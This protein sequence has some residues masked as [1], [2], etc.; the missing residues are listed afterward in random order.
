VY[1]NS[2]SGYRVRFGNS[3]NLHYVV[4]AFLEENAHPSELYAPVLSAPERVEN[5]LLPPLDPRIGVL[6]RRLATGLPPDGQARAIEAYLQKEFGYTTELLEQRVSDP[7]AHFLFNR[8]KGHCEY[9]SSAMA[10]MLRSLNIPARVANGFQ[11]GVFNPVSG[12]YVIRASDAHSWVEAW[13]PGR[14]WTTFDPTPP[15]AA[16]PGYSI[17]TR[18]S[19]YLDA[20]ETFW[21]EWVLNYDLERQIILASKMESGGR[22]FGVR[23]LADWRARFRQAQQSLI[24]GTKQYGAFAVV[25]AAFA[26]ASWFYLPHL[27]RWW[28]HRQR[29]REAQRGG[30]R[31]SDATL[32]YDR[33]LGALRRRGFEKP[34]WTT[35]GEFARQLPPSDTSALVGDFTSAYHNLR[36]G[37]DRSVAPRMVALLEELEKR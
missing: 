25:L 21:H 28:K 36:Y 27:L 8:R 9:F 33:M 20:A 31:P 30:A 7:L 22:S 35:P 24:E 34:A 10:V 19:F 16:A 26:I 4:Y 3:E 29:V 1:G 17:W 2:Q 6:A 23:W 11:S 18:M 12:W 14:G 32:L 5:L 13:L 37:G 15:S